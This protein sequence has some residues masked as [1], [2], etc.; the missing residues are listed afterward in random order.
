MEVEG[1]PYGKPVKKAL[2]A[3][4]IADLD[5]RAASVKTDVDGLAASL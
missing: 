2:S 4:Q 1:R 5:A 3:E